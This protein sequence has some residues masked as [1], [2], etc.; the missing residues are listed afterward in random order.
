MGTG[1]CIE[2]VSRIFNFSGVCL[3]AVH[4]RAGWE[5]TAGNSGDGHQVRVGMG[6]RSSFEVHDF[7]PGGLK[8][9]ILSRG[10][11]K[12][13]AFLR[14]SLKM[15]LLRGGLKVKSEVRSHSDDLL[16]ERSKAVAG[17]DSRQ[18]KKYKPS[19]SLRARC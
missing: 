6:G 3:H 15:I 14:T 9:A 7:V 13:M 2:S 11:F 16:S 19:S 10:S 8:V 1:G 4:V 12:V 17:E 18:R 5:R